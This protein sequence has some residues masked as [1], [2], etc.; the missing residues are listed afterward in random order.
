[1]ELQ[2]SNPLLILLLITAVICCLAVVIATI[3]HLKYIRK[4]KK[5]YNIN[6]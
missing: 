2:K 6:Q 5:K 4:L 3:H 1:M